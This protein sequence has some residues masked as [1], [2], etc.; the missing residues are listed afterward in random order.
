MCIKPG[1][2]FGDLINHWERQSVLILTAANYCAVSLG[3]LLKWLVIPVEQMPA[4]I[5]SLS[6]PACAHAQPWHR[7]VPPTMNPLGTALPRGQRLSATVTSPP[8]FPS[9][10]PNKFGF[11]SLIGQLTSERQLRGFFSSRVRRSRR[12][13]SNVERKRGQESMLSGGCPS[14]PRITCGLK[15]LPME[16]RETT[17]VFNFLVQAGRAESSVYQSHGWEGRE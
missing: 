4:F 7:V 6:S 8:D 15:A 9:D 1:T 13:K 16:G 11:F 3:K 10:K 5:P 17:P 2:F 12:S 14:P